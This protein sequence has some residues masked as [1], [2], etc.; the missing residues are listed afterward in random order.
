MKDKIR[1]L[2]HSIQV[3]F[4]EFQI[5]FKGGLRS[6]ILFENFT[7]SLRN[8]LESYEIYYDYIWGKDSVNV[9]GVTNGEYIPQ[10]GDTLIMDISVGKDGVWCDVCRTF[11]VGSPTENHREIF[12]M[13]KKALREG[14]KALTPKAR[15]CDVYKNVNAFFKKNG[16]KLVHHAG[17]RIG[18]KPL[19]QPQFLEGNETSLK[20]GEFYTIEPGCYDE[21]GIRLENDFLLT[22]NGATDLFEELMPL[23]IDRYILK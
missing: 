14:Q 10:E 6:E 15:A 9:D 20:V 5:K 7:N 21:F 23:E 8:T 11:F 22:E 12:E 4:G 18:S 19:L 3:A 2:L 1:F 17:H 16:K 13:L